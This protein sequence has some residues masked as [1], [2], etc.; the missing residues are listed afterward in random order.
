MSAEKDTNSTSTTFCRY[1]SQL[2]ERNL[3]QGKLELL[4]M[5]L[6]MQKKTLQRLEMKWQYGKILKRKA[7]EDN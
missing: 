6:L 3:T 1:M 2:N 5:E 7:T 4:S